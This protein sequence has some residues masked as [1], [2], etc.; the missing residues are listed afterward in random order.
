M[1]LSSLCWSLRSQS[2]LGFRVLRS[3]MF[4]PKVL[5]IDWE[6]WAKDSG[7]ALKPLQDLMR[8]PQPPKRTAERQTEIHVLLF[9]SFLAGGPFT[10]VLCNTLTY[11]DYHFNIF[12]MAVSKK[13]LADSF[14]GPWE[15]TLL[16]SFWEIRANFGRCPSK[17]NIYI[18]IYYPKVDTWAVNCDGVSLLQDL[19]LKQ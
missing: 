12:Q 9:L 7:K 1:Q 16:I 5:Q 10:T 3:N 14:V 4:Q 11:I 19:W 6:S 18:Y 17:H 8:R 13:V 2:P 15:W